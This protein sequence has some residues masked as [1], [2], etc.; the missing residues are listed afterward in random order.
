VVK[1][2]LKAICPKGVG[3]PCSVTANLTGRSGTAIAASL[4]A[5]NMSL[6]PG[7]AWRASVALNKVASKALRRDRRVKV[8]ALVAARTPDGQ[9]S[10]KTAKLTLKKP[11]PAKRKKRKGR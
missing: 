4:G 11:A 2:P 8:L 9:I 3:A 1:L 6:A 5:R 7:K 10:V